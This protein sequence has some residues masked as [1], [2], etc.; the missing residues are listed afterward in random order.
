MPPLRGDIQ[1]SHVIGQTCTYMHLQ[2]KLLT[3]LHDMHADLCLMSPA[4][5]CEL[6]CTLEPLKA[7]HM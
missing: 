7:T 5:C 2:P 3:A 4:W 1:N 6:I